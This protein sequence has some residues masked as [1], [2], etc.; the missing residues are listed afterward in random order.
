[1]IRRISFFVVRGAHK[2]RRGVVYAC[3]RVWASHGLLSFVLALSA[4]AIAHNVFAQA[5]YGPPPSQPITGGFGEYIARLYQIG[6]SIV[7]VTAFFSIVLGGLQYTVSAGN[8]SKI[9]DAKDRIRSAIYG[10]A[11]LLMSYILLYTINPRIIQLGQPGGF[12]PTNQT[13]YPCIPP[14]QPVTLPN[15]SVVCQ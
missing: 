5:Q 11:L 10:V 15:G 8:P 3:G 7:G 4:M 6:F 12:D 14:L 1:M 2:A 13:L 9:E